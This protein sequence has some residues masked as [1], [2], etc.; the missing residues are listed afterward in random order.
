MKSAS[1]LECSKISVKWFCSARFDEV[2][3]RKCGQL[4]LVNL[5]VQTFNVDLTFE[6]VDETPVKNKEFEIN[7]NSQ[8][9]TREICKFS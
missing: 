9:R 2:N 3:L 5:R 7:V 4:L 8:T 1:F 6:S